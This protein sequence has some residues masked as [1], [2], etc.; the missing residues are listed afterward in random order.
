MILSIAIAQTQ[1]EQDNSPSIT[2]FTIQ[3]ACQ[4]KAISETSADG[5]GKTDCATSAGFISDV[6]STSQSSDRHVLLLQWPPGPRPREKRG[7][8]NA[9][10][11]AVMCRMGGPVQ[12]PIPASPANVSKRGLS[13]R[14]YASNQTPI[15]V[16]VW[17][18]K[19]I[20]GK[21]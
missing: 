21:G 1:T 4:N 6:L 9:G 7:R 5:S 15:V 3:C 12:K 11:E 10:A 20:L 17:L 18:P 14:L 13:A 2:A 19:G 16:N 8:K